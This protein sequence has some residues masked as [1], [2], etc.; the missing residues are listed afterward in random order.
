VLI[1][2]FLKQLQDQFRK[3]LLLFFISDVSSCSLINT[4]HKKHHLKPYLKK[5]SVTIFSIKQTSTILQAETLERTMGTVLGTIVI[6]E[7]TKTKPQS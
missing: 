7:I 5:A 1:S 3:L 4:T 2:H 6:K